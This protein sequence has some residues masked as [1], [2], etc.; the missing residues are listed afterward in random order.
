MIK[1]PLYS[2]LVGYYLPILHEYYKPLKEELNGK[3]FEILGEFTCRGYETHG[4][5]KL[6]GDLNKGRPNEKNIEEAKEFI[7][8]LET[9]Q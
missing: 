7:R 4:I 2:P 6:I 5:F 1:R 3:G 9:G 8:N